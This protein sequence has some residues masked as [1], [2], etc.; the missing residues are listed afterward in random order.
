MI[1][2]L[3]AS[4][5]TFFPNKV[6]LTGSR[7]QDLDVS[8][9]GPLFTHPLQAVRPMSEATHQYTVERGAEPHLLDLVHQSLKC[10]TGHVKGHHSIS[11]W[12]FPST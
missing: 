9:V 4:A 7:G 12:T 1:P 2:T 11:C 3:I 5:K 8:L 6:I 10:S